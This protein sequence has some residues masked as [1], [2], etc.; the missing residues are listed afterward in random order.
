MNPTPLPTQAEICA[1][2]DYNP[3]T[4]VFIWKVS[5]SSVKAGSVA[6]TIDGDGYRMIGFV[7]RR[8]GSHRI[9]WVIST[10]AWPIDQV[11]HINGIR[12]DNRIVN[13]REATDHQNQ[14]NRRRAQRN[15]KSGFL[16]VCFHKDV[17]KWQ[18]Q[19][20]IDG[21]NK[22]LGL[23]ATPELAHSAYL[24]AKAVFH[25]FQTIANTNEKV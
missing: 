6:G 24:V 14:Q 20:K 17:G 13:L 25:P 9:A 16:G 7:R 22:Y 15:S 2:L 5:R 19:I 21:K 8:L 18:A 23:Y 11:D 10:G 4:G 1:M 12:D 3:D